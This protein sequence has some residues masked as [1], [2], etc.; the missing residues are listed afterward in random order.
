V[1][2]R[3]LAGVAF[4]LLAA[5]PAGAWIWVSNPRAHALPLPA[6]LV[7]LRSDEGGKLLAQATAR[8]DYASLS[9]AFE[10]Q[11]KLSWCGVASSAVVLR[12]AGLAVRQE[13]LLDEATDAVRNRWRVMFGGMTLEHLAGILRVKGRSTEAHHAD[14][15][16]LD[17]FR[18]AAIAN[19]AHEGDWLVVDYARAALG[20]EGGGHI[21]PIAAYDAA[22]D[23]LLVLDVA[24]YR[25]PPVW[26]TVSDLWGAMTA[27]DPDSGRSRG[28]V[29]VR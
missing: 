26:V 28:W 18:E 9:A 25:Y 22:T 1:K 21:S 19:L 6:N 27:T 15:T 7:S 11:E 23:R 8:A 10:A 3:I 13:A 14:E 12:A 16:T 4:A 2:P 24:A 29:E 20:Q 17:A 5:I